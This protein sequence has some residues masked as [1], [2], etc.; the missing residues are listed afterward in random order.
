MWNQVNLIVDFIKAIFA[1]WITLDKDHL[2][3]FL[4]DEILGHRS[5]SAG[6]LSMN[7]TFWPTAYGKNCSLI[8]WMISCSG[9][10]EERQAY[11]ERQHDLLTVER[12][13]F[14]LLVRMFKLL[15]Q[16]YNLGLQELRN[17]LQQASRRLSGNGRPAGCPGD[18]ATPTLP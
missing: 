3:A 15:H 6:P 11:L 1:F 5:R 9:M 7:S 16:K 10:M 8:P 13:R 14:E 17:Q 4:P 2:R 12:K 18:T